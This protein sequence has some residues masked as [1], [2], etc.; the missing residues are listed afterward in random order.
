MD[1][2]VWRAEPVLLYISSLLE[3]PDFL[4]LSFWGTAFWSAP[5]H[6]LLSHCRSAMDQSSSAHGQ[7]DAPVFYKKMDVDNKLM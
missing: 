6:T 4:A 2:T 1:T 3:G 7:V 5:A